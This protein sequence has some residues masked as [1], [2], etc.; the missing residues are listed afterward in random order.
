MSDHTHPS[1]DPQPA[2]ELAW[3]D[4]S[5][6]LTDHNLRAPRTDD[7][8]RQLVA[9]IREHGV[10]VPI[11]AVRDHQGV[12][13]RYG[14]RRALAAVQAGRELVPVVVY[15]GSLTDAT[16]A[17]IDRI[18]GQHAEN[19]HRERLTVGETIAAFGQLAA[20]GQSPARIARRSK[21]PRKTVD[22]ALAAGL[23]R[24]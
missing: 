5:T 7:P 11:V 9:S 6:L 16:A 21:T 13:V 12:R 17:E 23:L 4:P 15:T 14:H 20:L 2:A 1:T 22:H 10:L 19:T 18:L 24:R 8:F 3:L